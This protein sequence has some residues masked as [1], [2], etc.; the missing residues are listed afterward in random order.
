ME[1]FEDV[2]W[3]AAFVKGKEDYLSLSKSSSINQY[4]QGLQL[5]ENVCPYTTKKECCAWKMGWHYGQ[6]MENEIYDL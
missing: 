6:R 2:E 1:L 3:M 4:R 5:R